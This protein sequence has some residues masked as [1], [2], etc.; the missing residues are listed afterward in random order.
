M[1]KKMLCLAMTAV[2]AV[3]MS[4]T[5]YAVDYVGDDGWRAEFDGDSLNSN[6]E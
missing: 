4:S 6:F 3:G 2:M 5:V 1:K